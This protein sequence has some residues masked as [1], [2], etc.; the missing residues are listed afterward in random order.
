[1]ARIRNNFRVLKAQMETRLGRS[2]TYEEMGSATGI[3][4]NTL[5]MYNQNKVSRYDEN[6]VI[7]LCQYFDCSLDELLEYPPVLSLEAV[8]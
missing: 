2:I 1:M 3:S 4:P 7:R 6:T 8:K 5:S